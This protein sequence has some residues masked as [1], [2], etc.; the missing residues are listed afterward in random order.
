MPLDNTCSAFKGCSS[1][2]ISSAGLFSI[3]G[4]QVE[5]G[6]AK[7]EQTA[8]TS[9]LAA[10]FLG[11]W[12][13]LFLCQLFPSEEDREASAALTFTLWGSKRRCRALHSSFPAGVLTPG[14]PHPS[15]QPPWPCRPWGTSWLDV[16]GTALHRPNRS[17]TG[18]SV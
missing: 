4:N 5:L 3:L 2:L 12:F 14:E 10:G 1:G 17:W 15:P 6:A 7:M 13:P 11:P 9:S 18:W 8:P 16:E